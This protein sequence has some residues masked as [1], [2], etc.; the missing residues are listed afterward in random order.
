MAANQF[1]SSTFP[2]VLGQVGEGTTTYDVSQTFLS[3]SVSLGSFYRAAADRI[4]FFG[5]YPGPLGGPTGEIGQLATTNF[6][7]ADC[8]NT[9]FDAAF[10]NRVGYNQT[11]DIIQYLG[12]TDYHFANVVN[13]LFNKE[14]TPA[15]SRVG[16]V[17]SEDASNAFDWN[18]HDGDVAFEAAKRVY[19]L[20]NI[21]GFSQTLENTPDVEDLFDAIF[22]T[23]Q[24]IDTVGTDFGGDTGQTFLRQHV[25]FKVQGARCPEK[26]YTPFVGESGDDSYGEVS[27]GPNIGPKCSNAN[28]SSG[29]TNHNVDTQES[30]IR[31]RG[32]CPV[33]ED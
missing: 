7:Y 16:L 5:E 4:F 8:S 20:S 21:I 19:P 31:E 15:K 18:D 32:R 27:N 23:G 22:A 17:F 14:A 6:S 3:D 9:F 30:G 29:G 1:G 25:A 12:F 11:V 26:E 10:D 33:Y 24:V 13:I 2:F 28:L